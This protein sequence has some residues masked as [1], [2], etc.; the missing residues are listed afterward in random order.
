MKIEPLEPVRGLKAT[1]FSSG[2]HN[3]KKRSLTLKNSGGKTFQDVLLEVRHQ[4]DED[5]NKPK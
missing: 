5:R 2:K 3:P 1:C 4:R